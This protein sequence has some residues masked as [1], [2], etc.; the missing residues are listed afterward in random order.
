MLPGINGQV[1]SI[2][3]NLQRNPITYI[4]NKKDVMVRIHYKENFIS[5]GLR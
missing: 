3:N 2:T 5:K 4:I 1:P